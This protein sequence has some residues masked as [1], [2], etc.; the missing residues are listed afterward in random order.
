MVQDNGGSVIIWEI[1]SL[2]ML[3]PLA[4]IKDWLND[5]AHLS[6]VDDHMP[7]FMITLPTSSRRMHCHKLWQ[8]ALLNTVM[9]VKVASIIVGCQPHGEPFGM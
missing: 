8:I 7:Q 2:Y 4:S 1:F 6:I 3:G 9:S 5:A